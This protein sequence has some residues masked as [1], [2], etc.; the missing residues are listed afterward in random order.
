MTKQVVNRKGISKSK[1]RPEI[2]KG[3]HSSMCKNNVGM[4]LSQ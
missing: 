1:H 2:V 3:L 4:G